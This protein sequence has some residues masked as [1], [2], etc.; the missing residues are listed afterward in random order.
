[1]SIEAGGR[2]YRRT[3]R[4]DEEAEKERRKIIKQ[5][6]RPLSEGPFFFENLKVDDGTMN[7]YRS[8]LREMK[9]QQSQRNGKFPTVERN[10]DSMEE[11]N[12][13][14]KFYGKKIQ[15]ILSMEYPQP[16][17]PHRTADV[18]AG[19]VARR[20]E[21][22]APENPTRSEFR[23]VL[24][25]NSRTINRPRHSIG[26]TMSRLNAS[27]RTCGTTLSDE[28]TLNKKWASSSDIFKAYSDPS[29]SLSI[30]RSGPVR[31]SSVKNF[32]RKPD[33]F[34]IG[35]DDDLVCIDLSGATPRTLSLD[36]GLN[37]IGDPQPLPAK[38]TG[39]SASSTDLKKG[40]SIKRKSKKRLL[41][42]AFSLPLQTLH[43]EISDASRPD[44]DFGFF[45][46][47]KKNQSSKISVKTPKAKKTERVAKAI[48]TEPQ[49]KRLTAADIS[50]PTVISTD[51]ISHINTV[52]MSLN[53]TPRVQEQMPKKKTG[54]SGKVKFWTTKMTQKE[55][56]AAEIS[57][58]HRRDQEYL[59]LRGK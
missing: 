50:G 47:A 41:S 2:I 12:S 38:N 58:Q 24:R 52:K 57:D 53:P 28:T 43:E 23:T 33:Y 40:G 13:M 55:K 32:Q 18:S 30:R 3:G 37:K 17:I 49:K 4:L 21:V 27:C 9:Q 5:M 42:A 20:T 46:P 25:S 16:N 26:S 14:N 22:K 44:A 54:F 45:N 7:W 51:A 34:Q 11:Q 31:T 35:Q 15:R 59:S 10:R 8:V 1:M 6:S 39:S 36:R 19:H 29:T 56:I 48:K